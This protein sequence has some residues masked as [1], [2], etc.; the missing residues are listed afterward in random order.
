MCGG[1]T[2][3]AGSRMGAFDGRLEDKCSRMSLHGSAQGQVWRCWGAVPSEAEWIPALCAGRP[4][5]VPAHLGDSKAQF[6][7]NLC[8]SHLFISSMR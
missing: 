2:D 5:H 1:G 6:Y 8:F 7:C 3:L 4:P